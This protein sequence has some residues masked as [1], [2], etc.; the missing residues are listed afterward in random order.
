[1]LRGKNI[2]LHSVKTTHSMN[3]TPQGKHSNTETLVWA[4]FY[5]GEAITLGN[6]GGGIDLRV[7][8]MAFPLP[9]PIGDGGWL[10]KPRPSASSCK[11][12]QHCLIKRSNKD[13]RRSNKAS[14]LSKSSI[15]RK[16]AVLPLLSPRVYLEDTSKS[17]KM[18]AQY[19]NDGRCLVRRWEPGQC[20]KGQGALS[21][22]AP[23][24]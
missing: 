8:A 16:K 17:W 14:V 21:R 2:W 9:P 12:E 18:G 22:S 5:A 24:G 7:A 10:F 11:R 4:Y 6:S 3:L 19:V 20:T 13:M 15:L 1:M 23:S